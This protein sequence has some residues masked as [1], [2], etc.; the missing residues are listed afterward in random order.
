MFG[1]GVTL[2]INIDGV[3]YA[4]TIYGFDVAFDENLGIV[5]LTTTML[6]P[7]DEKAPELTTLT[8]VNI[9]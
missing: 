7:V 8:L 1:S 3:T 9:M 4:Y 2:N 5:T 6:S